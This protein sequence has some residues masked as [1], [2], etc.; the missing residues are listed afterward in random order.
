MTAKEHSET[1][2]IVGE[3]VLIA[4]ALDTVV[5]KVVIAVLHLGAAPLVESVVA[6]LDPS[7][8][9]EMLKERLQHIDSDSWRKPIEKFIGHVETVNKHRNA[10]CHTPPILENDKWTFKPI[11]AAKLLR[12]L[13]A[14]A[15]KLQPSL[16]MHDLKNAIGLGEKA[17]GEGMNILDN[18]A[19]A[20][21]ERARRDAAKTQ[22]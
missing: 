13:D 20:E 1:Y 4:S 7:R 5:N 8:K 16:A 2:A 19:R 10:A 17:L 3:M 12:R 9:L 14:K 15:K 6:T 22:S 18:F 11:A 21:A